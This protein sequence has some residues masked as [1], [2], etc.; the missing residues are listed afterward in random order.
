[1][2]PQE[3]NQKD[4]SGQTDLLEAAETLYSTLVSSGLKDILLQEEKMRDN[5]LLSI[6][7]L[8]PS[9]R[10]P[11]YTMKSTMLQNLREKLWTCMR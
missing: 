1:M 4:S 9:Y 5:E 11:L 10:K 2:L 8:C 3:T 6:L 7:P